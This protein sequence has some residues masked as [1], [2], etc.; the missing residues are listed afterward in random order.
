MMV[1][2]SGRNG[3]IRV[4]LLAGILLTAVLLWLLRDRVH[5]HGLAFVLLAVWPMLTWALWLRGHWGERLLSAGALVLLLNALV[6]L[7]LG[8]IPGEI[9]FGIVLAGTAV[10]AILPLVFVREIE[11]PLWSWTAVWPYLLVFL[12]AVLFRV[13][14]LSYSEFQG[15]EG[16]IMVRAAAMIMGDDAELFLHQKGPIEILQPLGM[17]QLSGTINEAWARALFTW[18]SLLSVWAVMVLAWHWF[19]RTVGIWAGVLLALVGFSVAFGRIVQYQSFVVLWGALALVHAVGYAREQ[20]RVDLL[21]TAVFLAGGLLAHYDAI[22]VAPA[23]GWVLLVSLLNR[24]ERGGE[25]RTWWID[26]SVWRDYVWAALAGALV[27]GAFYV[28]FLLNPNFSRTGAYLLQDRIGV[29]ESTGI[30]S[31][32]GTAVWRMLTLYNSTYFIIGLGIF[33]LIGLVWLVRQRQGMA[34]ILYFFTP[35]LFYLFIV[36]DPRTHVYTFFG[37]GVILAA[38]GIVQAGYY[39]QAKQVWLGRVGVAIVGVWLLV[40]AVYVC[41]M[42]IDNTP[43]RMRTWAENRPSGYWVSW[44][45]PPLYGL[46]GFPHQAGWRVAADLVGEDGLPYASNEEQEIT[47]WYMS[48]APRTHC[49]NF[50]TFVLAS[51]TQ[52]SVLY[53]EAQLEG[54]FLQ[55]EVL[56]NDRVTMQVYGRQPVETLITTEATHSQFWQT[57]VQAAPSSPAISLPLNIVLGD[58]QAVLLGYDL[59]AN[60]SGYILVT[61]YWQALAP[62]AEN[63]QTFVHLYGEELVAQNDGTPDCGHMPTVR[64]EPGQIVVDPHLIIIPEGV[65][66]AETPVYVGM[67]S[68]LTGGR[69]AVPGGIDNMIYLTDVSLEEPK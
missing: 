22:L 52:D 67:Y 15:D 13:P 27:L 25:K 32:S 65:S 10:I 34:A 35:V 60:E 66:V 46:F 45:E 38:V 47:R 6:I 59:A 7:L 57:P 11:L 48:H 3:R 28:P 54:M 16:V 44:D 40:T 14:N 24:G 43:E 58:D 62:F 5:L 12:I 37:G 8:Y 26:F 20:R 33:I 53:D 51:N 64:W 41:A 69:L 56:V 2:F 21:F 63:Y 18:A 9:S 68:L 61:L 1:R 31:W 50:N 39:L 29:S 17:W 19:G 30:F 4:L 23:I 42:F 49:N 36:V 55:R